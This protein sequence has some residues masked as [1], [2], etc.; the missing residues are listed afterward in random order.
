MTAYCMLSTC[1]LFNEDVSTI[2]PLRADRLFHLFYDQSI[3]FKNQFSPLY[4]S[5]VKATCAFIQAKISAILNG[6]KNKT[7]FQFNSQPTF[8]WIKEKTQ[9]PCLSLP[10]YQIL[11]E[12]K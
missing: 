1:M 10:A 12:K 2:V 9:W 5:T 6:M 8:H 11:C 4:F 3:C 7:F